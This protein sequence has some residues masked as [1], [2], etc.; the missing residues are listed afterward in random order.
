[1]KKASK[2][3]IIITMIY[4]A[5]MTVLSLC[6]LCVLPT[7]DLSTLEGVSTLTYLLT[8]AITMIIMCIPTVIV[9]FVALAKLKKSGKP[10][11][12]IS[13]V[14]LLFCNIVAGILM[15]CTPQ[16]SK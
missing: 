9:G 10:S 4:V 14:T 1:M 16:N 5:V 15:L 2:I 12:A 8:Y 3:I 11:I 7:L 13:I 6:S